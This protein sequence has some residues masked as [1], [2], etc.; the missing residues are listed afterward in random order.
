MDT[1]NS[2][3]YTVER[4]RDGSHLVIDRGADR[5]QRL[6]IS[7]EDD[8]RAARTHAETLSQLE[9][10]TSQLAGSGDAGMDEMERAALGWQDTLDR[11]H[12]FNHLLTDDDGDGQ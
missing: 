6:A 4:G 5:G 9:S 7:R 2:R 11:E 3:R 10:F 8:E 12:N 1:D